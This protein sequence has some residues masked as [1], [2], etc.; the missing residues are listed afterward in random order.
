MII[1]IGMIVIG[2]VIWSQKRNFIVKENE[3]LMKMG[4]LI[5]K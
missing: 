5:L 1:V 3:I 4:R 2:D